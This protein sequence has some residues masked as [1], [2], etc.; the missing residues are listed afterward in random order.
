MPIH[1]HAVNL[2][3]RHGLG[4][5]KGD[6][7]GLCRH[8]AGGHHGGSTGICHACGHSADIVFGNGHTSH[9]KRRVG[10]PGFQAEGIVARIHRDINAGFDGLNGCGQALQHARHIGAGA[11]KRDGRAVDGDGVNAPYLRQG[12]K[13]DAVALFGVSTRLHR[14]AGTD[15]DGATARTLD[16]VVTQGSSLQRDIKGGCI[17]RNDP[18]LQLGAC[19]FVHARLEPDRGQAGAANQRDGVAIQVGRGLVVGITGDGAAGI[20][21]RGSPFGQVA[22]GLHGN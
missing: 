5:A 22:R 9:G 8:K 12:A 10:H 1:H 15:G 11:G 7:A 18:R 13:G 3:G 2:I 19:A 20:A 17:G 6:R 16:G 21:Y 4:C 14:G